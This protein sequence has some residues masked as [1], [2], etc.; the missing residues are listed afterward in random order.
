[1]EKHPYSWGDENIILPSLQLFIVFNKSP[2]GVHCCFVLPTIEVFDTPH[3]PLQSV[4]LFEQ[5]FVQ[6]FPSIK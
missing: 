1:M 6:S 3:E 4:I 5:S 2:D